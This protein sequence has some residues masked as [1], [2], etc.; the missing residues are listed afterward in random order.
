MKWIR[1]NGVAIVLFA[2]ILALMLYGFQDAARSSSEEGLRMTEDAL[3]RAVVSCYAL[4]GR[5]PPDVEYLC[6]QYGLQLNEDKYIVHYEIF[7]ENIMPD[8][9]V[10]ER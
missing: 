9:T 5:Y 2:A 4:E 8:I 10:L 6:Q 3:R 7:A 1:D